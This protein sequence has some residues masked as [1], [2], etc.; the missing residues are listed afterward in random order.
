MSARAEYDAA[1]FTLLRARE[2]RD[3]LLRY[4]EYLEA[5]QERLERF[6]AETRELMDRLPRKV[7]R[8]IGA[9]TKGVLEAIGRRRSAVLDER[10]KMPDRLVNA[11]RFVEECERE[12]ESLR[13]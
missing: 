10:K 3:D 4:G 12:V 8:P 7:A 1:Y 2:E 5:E 11:E 13:P 9:T 6:A